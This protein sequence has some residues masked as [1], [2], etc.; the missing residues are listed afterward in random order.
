[1]ASLLTFAKSL[2][3]TGTRGKSKWSRALYDLENQKQMHKRNIWQN[4]THGKDK[5]NCSYRQ[6]GCSQKEQFCLA[7]PA[8][9]FRG[10]FWQITLILAEWLLSSWWWQEDSTES[11]TPELGGFTTLYLTQ[12][13]PWTL[14]RSV[15]CVDCEVGAGV[16]TWR[17]GGFASWD[18]SVWWE[19][20]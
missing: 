10:L 20:H 15:S 12:R 16:H 1:M 17:S 13:H 9:S 11:C 19:R 7:Q 5:S 14:S 4:Q 2:L 6:W 18:P 3:C 8:S